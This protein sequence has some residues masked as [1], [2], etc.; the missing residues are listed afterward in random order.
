MN[1]KELHLGAVITEHRRKRGVTQEELAEH[2]GVSKASVSKWETGST[3]PDITLL[4]RLAAFFGLTVDE[5][6]GYEP[7]LTKEEIRRLYHEICRRFA[8]EPFS[9]GMAVC[10]ET[11]KEYFSCFPLLLQIGALILNH[12][13]LADSP[14]QG[15]KAIEE[16][17]LLLRRVRQESGDAGLIAQAVNLEA[18]CL[19]QLGRAEEVFPLLSAASTL[20]MAPEPLLSQAYQAVGNS[21]E[22]E[23]LL[24]VGIYQSALELSSLLTAYLENRKGDAAAFQET[25]DRAL[26]VIKAFR[27]EALHPNTPLILYLTAAQGFLELGNREKALELLERYASLA[28]SAI[29]PIRLHGDPYFDLL[30]EWLEENLM[31]GSAPPRDDVV[32]KK[33][34]AAALTE[35]PAF[36]PL[37][38]EPGFQALCRRFSKEMTL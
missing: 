13:M 12:F 7:Q 5:L 24:Q 22:A 20:R 15:Q 16:A 17:L 8:E 31:L 37:H 36:A 11:A 3:Y 30:N 1:K 18:M 27:L 4:P 35:N 6:L 28:S 10:R 19:F 38:A 25:C 23:K 21:R 32:I 34:I 2:M 14:E 33:D 26:A 29:F 9:A